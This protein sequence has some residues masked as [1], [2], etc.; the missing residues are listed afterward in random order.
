MSVELLDATKVILDNARKRLYERSWEQARGHGNERA[1]KA[2]GKTASVIG[3]VLIGGG[4]LYCF[5]M[6]W[7][8]VIQ[9]W[10]AGAI[11]AYIL[12]P[13]LAL[14]IPVISWVIEG[15]FPVLLFA[16]WGAMILGGILVNF[17]GRD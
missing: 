12:S 4:Y 2:K 15:M 16:G 5:V 10:G 3:Y 6:L 8:N 13:F 11:F 17:A 9:W 1:S 14:A 7:V